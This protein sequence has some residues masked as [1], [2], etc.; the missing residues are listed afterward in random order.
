MDHVPAGCTP[1]Q[2]QNEHIELG[3]SASLSLFCTHKRRQERVCVLYWVRRT[4]KDDV[5]QHHEKDKPSNE[6]SFDLRTNQPAFCPS[7][8]LRPVRLP[9]P[10]ACWPRASMLSFRWPPPTE[11]GGQWWTVVDGGGSGG[12]GASVVCGRIS[13]FPIH[14]IHGTSAMLPTY[15]HHEALEHNH[16]RVYM[17][18]SY[19]III[20][21]DYG[22]MFL[23]TY[24]NCTMFTRISF[25]GHGSPMLVAAGIACAA[26]L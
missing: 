9:G 8:R 7:P 12:S 20:Q 11:A 10:R 24:W 26:L 3:F 4:L 6:G 16:R 13:W 14:G 25:Y 18:L 1:C 5:H 19:S 21:M 2:A 15:R 22:I 17:I 23:N